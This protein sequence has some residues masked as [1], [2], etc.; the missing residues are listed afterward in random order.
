MRKKILYLLSLLILGI[1]CEKEDQYPD[2]PEIRYKNFTLAEETENGFENTIGRLTFSFTDGDGD[3]GLDPNADSITD[4]TS[5]ETYNAFI[6]RFFKQKNGFVRDTTIGY[7][8]PYME[9]GEYRE[10]LKGEIEIKIYFNNFPHDTLRFDF[11][12]Y[13]RAN[14]KSNTESTPEIIVSEWI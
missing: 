10:Y 1:S 11:Y 2:I 14:H 6:T 3:I 8:I 4:T 12:I 13:D 5:T 7:I 9:G